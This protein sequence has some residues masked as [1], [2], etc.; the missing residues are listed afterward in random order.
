[1]TV[2]ATPL[3]PLFAAEISGIESVLEPPGLIRIE[4]L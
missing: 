3:H 4:A 1:M 2:T